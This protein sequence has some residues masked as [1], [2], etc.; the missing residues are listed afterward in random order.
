MPWFYGLCELDY[1]YQRESDYFSF[2]TLIQ[3]WWIL[4]NYFFFLVTSFLKGNSF[5]QFRVKQFWV[6]TTVRKDISFIFYL[7]S[8][9]KTGSPSP[10]W[11]AKK[12][13]LSKSVLLQNQWDNIKKWVFLSLIRAMYADNFLLIEVN[14]LLSLFSFVATRSVNYKIGHYKLPPHPP[15]VW[16]LHN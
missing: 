2:P 4:S 7:N 1:Y 3:N 12:N 11:F 8:L 9:G 10:L 16:F 15:W 13:T 5:F 14:I 6:Q